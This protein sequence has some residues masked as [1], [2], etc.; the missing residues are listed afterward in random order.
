MGV[1]FLS[2]FSPSNIEVI[3]FFFF[4]FCTR[5]IRNFDVASVVIVFLLFFALFFVL[6][7]KKK[8]CSRKSCVESPVS[9]N[10]RTGIVSLNSGLASV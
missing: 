4:F 1:F 5:T 8:N 2:F 9:G 7:F 10:G 3:F 6:I